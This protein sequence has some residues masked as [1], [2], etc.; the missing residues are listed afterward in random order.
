MDILNR[1]PLVLPYCYSVHRASIRVRTTANTN[2]TKAKANAM[3]RTRRCSHFPTV[4]SRKLTS[5]IC[6]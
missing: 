2:T 5:R 4:I 3:M 1:E 6:K